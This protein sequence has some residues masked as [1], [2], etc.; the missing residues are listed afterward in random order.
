MLIPLFSW[1]ENNTSP[2]LAEILNNTTITTQKN[3]NY[4]N[5]QQKPIILIYWTWWCNVCKQQLQNLNSLQQKNIEQKFH[6]MGI[7]VDDPQ[8]NHHKTLKIAHK[9]NFDNIYLNNQN[10]PYYPESIP[11]TIIFN[12]THQQIAKLEGIVD[13]KQIEEIMFSTTL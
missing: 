5:Y 11:T 2:K 6:I 8:K 13:A 7:S 1:A 4:Q 12:S 3:I 10:S 9:L